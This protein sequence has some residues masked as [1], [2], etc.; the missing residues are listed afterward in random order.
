MKNLGSFNDS[1]HVIK[2]LYM[3]TDPELNYLEE[4]RNLWNERTKIH[5]HSDFYD[6]PSFLEGKSSLNKIE[7]DILPDISN[8]SVL[9]LQCHFGMDSISLSRL[10]AHVTG[11]DL[12]DLSIEK[13]KELAG[14]MNSS[15]EFLCSDV[16]SFRDLDKKKYDC[17]F[18]SYGT[19]GWLPDLDKWAN[20]ISESLKPGGKF[21]FVEFHPFI[22]TF[23][24]H[25]TSIAFDFFTSSHFIENVE[26]SYAKRDSNMRETSVTWN[27][28]LAEVIK[29]L[30][31][32]GL[33]IESFDEY[34]Y[35]P[36]NCLRNMIEFEP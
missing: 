36:Y 22:W 29:A 19:I 12:S 28:G 21:V 30:Q 8:K 24:D 6:M 10:G 32:Q 2:N 9:H 20:V 33:Q 31:N 34:D 16:Y 26:G 14:K 7:L 5:I 17:V 11:I 35:S 1:N 27:H 3:P 4:N 23:D 18:T 15:A 25:F 13:A